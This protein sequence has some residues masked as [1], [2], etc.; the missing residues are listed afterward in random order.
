MH[1]NILSDQIIELEGFYS[2]QKYPGVLRR[3]EVW[4]KNMNRSSSS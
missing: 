1:R 4:T 2:Q 3:I